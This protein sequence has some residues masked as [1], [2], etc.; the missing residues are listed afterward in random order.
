MQI[1]ENIWNSWQIIS[2]NGKF[3]VKNLTIIRKKFE[4]SVGTTTSNL[5]ALDMSRVTQLDS[6]AI[7]LLLNFQ[8]RIVDKGGKLSLVGLNNEIAD[9]FS[10]VGIDKIFNLYPNHTSFEEANA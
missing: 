9:I 2:L 1:T 4:D 5:V 6:S 10:I 7:T 8:K 3:V